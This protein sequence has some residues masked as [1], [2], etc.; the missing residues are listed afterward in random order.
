MSLL[1]I[2]QAVANDIP[3]AAPNTI[4][5]NTDET[6]ALL[7]AQANLAG[8]ALARSPQGGWVTMIREYDFVTAAAGPINGSIANTGPN[9]V[10]RITGLSGISALAA[11][12]WYGFGN[13]LPNNSIIATVDSASQVTMNQPSTFT[14]AGQFTFGKSD[15]SLPSDFERPIDNTMWDRSRYWSMRGPQSPQQ[16]Q[17]YKSSV[18]GRASIQRRWRIRNIN[19]VNVFSIDPVP[20]D[21]KAALVFEYVSNGWCKSQAGAYQNTWQNDSDVGVLD[22]YLIQLGTRWRALRRLG[23]SYSEE[24]D[25]YERQVSKAAASDGGAA[26]L[27]I[28]P[29]SDFGFL[30]PWNIQDGNFP[31]SPN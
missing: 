17:M 4:I 11:L 1:T 8:E 26:I 9:G 5:G 18:I 23:M 28:S 16:W 13:G 12:A 20:T 6:A 14:G 2:A 15:Y 25:E 22:E 27:S 3:V 31:S 24:L 7:L 21:N 29:A 30:S 10:A 19:G